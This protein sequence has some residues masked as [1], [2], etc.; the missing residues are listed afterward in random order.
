V[1]EA[2]ETPTEERQDK[3]RTTHSTERTVPVKPE[4]ETRKKELAE[5]T[6]EKRMNKST[7]GKTVMSLKL[8]KAK[9]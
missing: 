3:R 5:P 2:V 1:A 6:G 4:E 7:K 8:K 9:L